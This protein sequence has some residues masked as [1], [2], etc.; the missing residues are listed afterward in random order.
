MIHRLLRNPAG[1]G[2]LL[3]P[4]VLGALCLLCT[5]GAFAAVDPPLTAPQVIQLLDQTVD[6][7][8]SFHFDTQ[9]ADEPSDE[10][11]LSDNERIAGQVLAA[12][13]ALGKAD[14]QLL[15]SNARSTAPTAAAGGDA[16]SLTQLQA[17]LTS[18]VE[19]IK[20]DIAAERTALGGAHDEQQR[21]TLTAK[22]AAQESALALLNARTA[23]VTTVINSSSERNGGNLG[24][25]AL[26]AQIDAMAASLPTQ[27]SPGATV[28]TKPAAGAQASTKSAKSPAVTP[29][30]LGLWQDITK[31]FHLALKLT[32]IESADRSTA[33]LQAQFAQIR[34]PLVG[35]LKTL[36]ARGDSL[37]AGLQQSNAP[38]LTQL[39]AQF[40]DLTGQFT[41]LSSVLE[42][43]AQSVLLLGQYRRSIADWRTATKSEYHE[44][45]AAVGLRFGVLVLIGVGLLG[46]AEIWKR[47]VL[48]YVPDVRHRNQL[49]LLRRI[50][51]WALVAALVALSFAS[52]LGSIVTFAGL[53]TAGLAV[54]MQSVLVSIVGYFFLIG[55]YG[56]RVGDRVQ[57]GEVTGEVI[58]LGL[59]RMYIMELGG[60]GLLGPTGRVVAFANSVV[61]QVSSGLFKQIPGVNFSWHDLTLNLPAGADYAAL[62]TRLLAALTHALSDYRAEIDRETK[63]LQETTS[64][65]FSVEA[66]PQV[67]L[68]F[69]AAGIQAL[70]RYP[71]Q[72]QRAAEID[73]RV[74][75]ELYDA[76]ASSARPPAMAASR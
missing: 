45:L 49:L 64:A 52:E 61:F 1:P 75:R 15:A 54:A 14:A 7:Y 68:Q 17:N 44:T 70:V 28:G 21:R 8:R 48:R 36:A 40:A 35:Q 37:Q 13:F 53:I 74:S 3:V 73:E 56:I 11:V 46:A 38:A 51:L 6:W 22:I 32:T 69:T 5:A 42:P 76:L 29:G 33:A 41:Q 16:G 24:P 58:D 23:L 43:L 62:K 63:T 59:V 9:S 20:T 2:R 10:V 72:L 57:I 30:G 25:G 55:K 4:T 71:V 66:K 18:Q 50:L 39:S 65:N 47:A 34:D 26:E 27:P 31:T 19:G 60:H 12:A 67:Q